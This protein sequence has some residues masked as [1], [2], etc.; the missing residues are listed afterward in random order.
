MINLAIPGTGSSGHLGGGLLLGLLLGQWASVLTMT[1]V[2]IIQALPI[3]LWDR[4][5]NVYAGV[6]FLGG[7]HSDGNPS[8]TALR[9]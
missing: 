8:S 3:S 5:G 7:Y 1:A 9:S 6:C 2:L 4:R